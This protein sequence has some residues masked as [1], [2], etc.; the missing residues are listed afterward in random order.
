MILLDVLQLC[1]VRWQK[2]LPIIL[3][4]QNIAFFCFNKLRYFDPLLA[5]AQDNLWHASQG[6]DF[7]PAVTFFNKTKA[8]VGRTLCGPSA[9]RLGW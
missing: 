4:N 5:A 6:T 9:E 8:P 7:A 1:E 3:L 2:G